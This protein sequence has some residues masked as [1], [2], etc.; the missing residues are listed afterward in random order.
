MSP[1]GLSGP[2]S[3]VAGDLDDVGILKQRE[4]QHLDDLNVA[5]KLDGA[6]LGGS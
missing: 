4:P 1:H 3:P 2:G 6:L 5:P